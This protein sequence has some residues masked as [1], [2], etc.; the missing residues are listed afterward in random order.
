MVFGPVRGNSANRKQVKLAVR[1]IADAGGILTLVPGFAFC[2]EN[3][4]PG[5]VPIKTSEF[6]AKCV[7]NR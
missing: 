3:I 5:I 6:A 2:G 4:V 1:K 7:P